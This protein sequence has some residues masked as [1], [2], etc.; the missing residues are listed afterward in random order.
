[1]TR[2]TVRAELLLAAAALLAGAVAGVIVQAGLE[3]ARGRREQRAQL[4]AAGALLDERDVE[5]NE[6]RALN[7]ALTTR[8]NRAELRAGDAEHELR[9]GDNG[10][11]APAASSS[12]PAPP[13]L[14]PAHKT[15]AELV[16]EAG[17]PGAIITAAHQAAL[18][19]VAAAAS[20][21]I[22]VHRMR[23]RLGFDAPELSE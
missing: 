6:L 2:S 8:A 4:R 5:L 16:R 1:M 19:R 20:T 11:A 14:S 17:E 3:V 9:S 21:A 15:D 12:T 7:Y 10:A 18:E 23:E 13:A 22:V